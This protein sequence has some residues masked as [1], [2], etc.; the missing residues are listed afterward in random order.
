[1]TKIMMV[2]AMA[3][4]QGTRRAFAQTRGRLIEALFAGSE[5]A[6]DVLCSA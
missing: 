6:V 3:A 5:A 4:S 1:M 2:G